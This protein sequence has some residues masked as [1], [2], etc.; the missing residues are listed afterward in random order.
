MWNAELTS[1]VAS[2]SAFRIPDSAWSIGFPQ[3][4]QH[5]PSPSLHGA[6]VTSQRQWQHHMQ[7]VHKQRAKGSVAAV[8][9]KSRQET[10]ANPRT[11]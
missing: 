1:T 5:T 10:E 9:D 11:S 7:A 3:T 2:H 4:G 6:A 8:I